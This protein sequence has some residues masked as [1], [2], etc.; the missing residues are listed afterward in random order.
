MCNLSEA[1][2]ILFHFPLAV[3]VKLLHRNVVLFKA[4]GPPP[5]T[6]QAGVQ[7]NEDPNL[8]L[9]NKRKLAIKLVF[10]MGTTP[11]IVVSVKASD[12]KE[13]MAIGSLVLKETG[14][15]IQPLT[16]SFNYKASTTSNLVSV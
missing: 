6:L 3:L 16:S 12:T 15:N 5:S 9:G 14:N 10:P 4:D 2:K 8:H 13:V 1:P 7:V 11:D